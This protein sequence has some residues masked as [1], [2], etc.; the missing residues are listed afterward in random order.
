[1]PADSEFDSVPSSR[2]H[3]ERAHVPLPPL[4]LMIAAGILVGATLIGALSVATLALHHPLW[5]IALNPWPR[6]LL[7]VAPHAPLVPFITVATLRGLFSCGVVYELARHYGDRAGEYM[8]SRSERASATFITTKRLFGRWSP[9]LLLVFPGM[10]TSVLAGMGSLPRT[11]TLLL[12][13]LGLFTW[14]CINHR[15]G[16]WLAPWTA[17]IVRFLSENMLSATLVIALAIGVYHLSQ[18]RKITPRVD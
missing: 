7:L 12:S 17:P 5:L 1:M 11:R 13:V 18:R 6:H 16:A 15:L 14:A 8:Q 3:V 10:T 9:V 2:E 4:W